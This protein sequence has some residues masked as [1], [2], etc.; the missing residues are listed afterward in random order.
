MSINRPNI[1]E[2]HRLNF[3]GRHFVASPKHTF[4]PAT[5]GVQPLPAPECLSGMKRLFSREGRRIECHQ[6]LA[7][8]TV[9]VNQR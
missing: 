5:G 2:N 6:L 3:S 4:L 8:N 7:M 1:K 9:I